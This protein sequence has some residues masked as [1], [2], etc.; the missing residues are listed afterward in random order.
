MNMLSH[1][2]L[3]NILRVARLA[4]VSF[5]TC[6]CVYAEVATGTIEGRVINP[7]SGQYLERVQITLSGTPLETFSD[8]GG[9][10]RL[11]N[12]AP[13]TVKLN[14]FYTSL[15]RYTHSVEVA[16]GQ[17]VRVDIELLPDAARA[18]SAAENVIKLAEFS[19]SESRAMAPSALAINEQR[20]APNIASVVSAAEYGAVSD[21]NVTE[22]VKFLPGTIISY[23]GG[24]ARE[25]SINGV[26]S[27]NVPAMVDGF[28]FG[29]TAPNALTARAA[30]VGFF[31]INSISRIQQDYS[32]T[33]ES[34]GAA[35]AGSLNM[36]T[37][38]AFESAH[39]T[40]NFN[41]FMMMRDN[42]RDFQAT[43]GPTTQPEKKVHPGFDFSAVVPV[44]Q[45]FGFTV[46]AAKNEGYSNEVFAATAWR[47][48]ALATN[49]TT[50]PV[51]TPDKPYLS[52]YTVGDHAKDIFRSS[53]GVTLDFK[54]TPVDRIS[55]VQQYSSFSIVF[56]NRNLA[57][58]ENQVLP[59]FT[60]TATQGA[61]GAGSLVNSN[62]G[63]Y[64]DNR[65]YLNTLRWLHN[66]P[67]N[68]VAVGV[69]YSPATYSFRVSD[70]G[71]FSSTTAQRTGVTV[72]FKDIAY[73]RPG[74]I[75][76]T[77]GAT[78]APVDPYQLGNYSL[79][80][81]AIAPQT[82]YD[83]RRTA[84]A[85]WGR[86][87]MGPQP[88]KLKIGLEFHGDVRDIRGYNQIYTY[89]GQ[90]G[91]P[92]TTP[93]GN[94]DSATPFIDQ[95]FSQRVGPWGFP[96]IQWL[97]NSL[98]YASYLGNPAAFTTNA[99]T[100]YRNAVAG[101]QRAEEDVPAA[102][103]RGDTAFMEGKLKLVGGV[104]VE[105]TNVTGEG[106]LNDPTRN[107]QR[108]SKGQTILDASGTPVPITTDPLA[109]S[110]LTY[111]NRGAVAKKEYL[112]YFPSL[113]ASYN[114]RENLIVRS[115]YYYSIGRPD[116]NQY[117][118]GVTLPNLE[119]PPGPNNMIQ[120]NNV[121][122]KPWN[123]KSTILRLEYYMAGGGNISAGA[124]RR[125][126]QDF[127]GGTTTPATSSFLAQYGLD[128]SIY[129]PYS[130]KTQVNLPGIVRIEGL[131]FNYKQALTFLPTWAHGLE[132]FANATTM[133]ATG[134]TLNAFTGAFVVPRSG[135]W[136]LH[137]SRDRF[138]VR[139]NWNYRS[140]NRQ[141][142]FAS[143]GSIEPSTYTWLPTRYQYDVIGEYRLT[144]HLSIYANLRN[145]GD[146]PDQVE[147]AGP[148]TPAVA[149]FNQRQQFGS[150]WTFG[151]KGTF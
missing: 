45:R 16:S 113:N 91:K 145:I 6:L 112:R 139:V 88:F 79:T 116:F 69:G 123:A 20:F 101:S 1:K 135:S 137:L 86:D 15:A 43:P 38:S 42:Y 47:G 26:P 53:F 58:N 127:F 44:N 85:N 3:L 8:A 125:D 63:F 37:R 50:F 30:Q 102:Y 28:D 67:V 31:S 142:L 21:G 76:V 136:G 66:G 114:I 89:V 19:V 130:V 107:F 34:Q 46:S 70:K 134:N 105:Q 10:Y 23:V 103:V 138:D 92:S 122:I 143:G 118:G 93:V 140:R 17:V 78:G 95:S 55:L 64:R 73:L 39:P 51:T 22:F 83:I 82:A 133:R 2:L 84:Y 9:F 108:N 32:S 129:G 146:A 13:G 150:L 148:D 68:R 120:V 12:V 96:K 35:L 106:P 54:L 48:V 126:F 115:A 5:G 59:D 94:D 119:N 14:A 57:F 141:T 111:I 77:D 33:P 24:D 97:S 25:V 104:R 62:T 100:N 18:T 109:A 7:V 41:I 151:V 98:T 80:S 4:F 117:F 87:F 121:G 124:F 49:G 81:T 131:T 110:V 60:T 132:V 99:N 40:Y 56:F 144:K 147:N 36:V 72:S 75:T 29:S 90:D 74:T 27:A 11:A 65:T 149:L 128:P 52:S 61:A 71:Y